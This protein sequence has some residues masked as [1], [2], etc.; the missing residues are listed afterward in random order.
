VTSDL[1]R[2]SRRTGPTIGEGVLDGDNPRAR[3]RFLRHPY[4][5]YFGCVRQFLER[6]GTRYD[7]LREVPAR[8]RRALETAEWLRNRSNAARALRSLFPRFRKNRGPDLRQPDHRAS[9]PPRRT[10]PCC[11]C[12]RGDLHAVEQ[13]ATDP[14]GGVIVAPGPPR[15]PP[16]TG[17]PIRRLNSPTSTWAN[18]ASPS[19]VARQ[20]LGATS[21]TAPPPLARPPP[22]HLA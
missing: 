1:R 5:V 2:G 19:P 7:N 14:P 13:L 6:W 10:S 9:S 8:Y 12:R 15:T 21:A 3:P 17:F 18:N 22:R 20:R 11:R 16:A 4:Y